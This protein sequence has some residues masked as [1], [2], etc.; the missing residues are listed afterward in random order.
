MWTR[1]DLI[2]I[3]IVLS[4][5]TVECAGGIFDYTRPGVFARCTIITGSLRISS[6]PVNTKWV[7]LK[8]ELI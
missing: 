5:T 7:E 6:A 2:D 4:S 8:F 3:V 1:Q